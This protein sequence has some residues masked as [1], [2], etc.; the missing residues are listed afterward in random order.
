MF[1]REVAERIVAKPG[2]KTYGRLS[3]LAGWRTRGEDPVRHRAVGLRAAA[4]GDLV[5]WCS[6]C[7][8]PR[9]LPCD[10]RALERVTAA[11]FGQRR[12]MLRASLKSLGARSHS[13][14]RKRRHRPDRARGGY[15]GRRFRRARQRTVMT[16]MIRQSMTA[17]ATPLCETVVEAPEPRGSEVLVRISRCG[18]CH[19]DI[20]LQDGYFSL[21]GDKKLDVTAPTQR[22]LPFTLGHEIAG[23][24]EKAGPD[25]EVETGQLVRGVS[26]DRLRRNARPAGGRGESVRGAAPSRHPGRR[27]LRHPC[28]GAASALPDR[29]HRRCRPRS[30][31]PT[32]ARAS[33]PIRRSSAS[34]SMPSADRCCWS[35][36]AASA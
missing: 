28:A 23:V 24:V 1:Q 13:A 19:S 15:C 9:P 31:A 30:P 34:P 16:R 36:S 5:A 6:S 26:L 35:G 12:K 21:G 8:A 17:Y 29:L 22:S 14:A 3:V 4:E 20:H 7:P 11:A 33:P 2:S 10:R 27:R 32:C 25:A 18:V